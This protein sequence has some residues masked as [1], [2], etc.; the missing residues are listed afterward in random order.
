MIRIEKEFAHG[1]AK[2]INRGVFLWN[3]DVISRENPERWLDDLVYEALGD[4]NDWSNA[5]D[6]EGIK[7]TIEIEQAQPE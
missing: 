4:E 5:F 7:I 2:P 3:G 1:Y 6:L